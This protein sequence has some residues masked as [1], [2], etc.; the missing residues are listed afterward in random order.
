MIKR[1]ANL[2]IDE[3]KKR[4]QCDLGDDT[5][6]VTSLRFSIVFTNTHLVD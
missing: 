2:G 6:K 5:R 3:L 1:A 4:E